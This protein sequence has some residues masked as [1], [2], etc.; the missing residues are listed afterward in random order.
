MKNIKE[1]DSQYEEITGEEGMENNEVETTMETPEKS[2]VATTTVGE[3]DREEGKKKILIKG[4][5]KKKIAG[6]KNEG[7]LIITQI[8]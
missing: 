6:M 4:K 3:E 7:E 2:T 1:E 8:K 5:G